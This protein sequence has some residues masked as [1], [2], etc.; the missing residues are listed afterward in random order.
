MKYIIMC[1]GTYR[2]WET[3]RHLTP[4]K[5]E[6]MIARTIRLLREAGVSDISISS[7]N[8]VFEQFGVPVLRHENS[9]DAVDYHHV[10][11]YWCDAFYPTDEPVCYIFGDV[12][13]SPEAIRRIVDYETDDIMFFGSKR[14]FAPNYPKKNV[15]PF[16][17]KVADPV[18][19]RKAC[20]EFRKLDDSGTY[21]R[22][23]IAWDLWFI[24][25]GQDPWEDLKNPINNSYIA[26]NDYTCDID[27]GTDVA[28]IYGVM[29]CIT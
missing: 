16:A 23:P 7:D 4:I 12:C 24:I 19:L 25:C 5:G 2:E 14:P 13:F 18:H 27:K 28:K 8:P 11:G 15:E 6:P 26:I 1:G 17:F 20:E 3:P 21:W 29:D 22:K 10:S 9:Y